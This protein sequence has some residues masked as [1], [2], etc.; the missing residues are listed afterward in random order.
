MATGLYEN[1]STLNF[2]RGFPLRSLRSPGGNM[3]YGTQF[4][5]APRVW[6]TQASFVSRGM[7]PQRV[8]LWTEQDDPPA[9]HGLTDYVIARRGGKIIY[10]K[11]A[12]SNAA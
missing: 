7:V 5:D 11:S 6:E 1:A 12:G 10:L 4:P 9:F 8:F 2:Y 3:W